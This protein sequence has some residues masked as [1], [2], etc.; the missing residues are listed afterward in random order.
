[1]LNLKGIHYQPATS[2]DAILRGIDLTV[3]VGNP[4]VISGESGSGKTS[5]VEIISGLSKPQKGS[6]HLNGDILNERQRRWI[7]GVVFQFPERHFLGLNIRQELRLGHRR[8]STQEQSKVLY[9]VGLNR[10]N[11][12]EAPEKLSGGEQRRLALATQLLKQPEI[13]LLDEPTA[14]L[15]W[16]VRNEIVEMLEAISKDKLLIIMSHE[17]ELFKDWFAS[18]F[19]LS[20]GKLIKINKLK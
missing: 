18:Y 13:L 2:D 19:E 9:K 20:N 4:A 14:G 6:V 3:H 15:D 10:I 7:S 5:L 17:P 11:L 12:K 16:S 1:M 8:L